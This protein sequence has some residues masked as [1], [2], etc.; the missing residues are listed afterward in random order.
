M[1]AALVK[2]KI[3]VRFAKRG[4]MRFISHLDLMRLFQRA[5]RRAHITVT[6]TQGFNPHPR[7][8]IEPALKL[9]EE[10]DSLE[11]AFKLDG[12]MAPADFMRALQQGLP[13]GIEL[14]K[15][16]MN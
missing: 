9:G 14:L 12:W 10:S 3:R 1:V 6:M 13:E 2:Q 5:A 11:A 4:L 8:S 16:M 15:A 7:I